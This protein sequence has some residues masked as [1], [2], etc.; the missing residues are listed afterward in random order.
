M[1]AFPEVFTGRFV[2]LEPLALAH[3]PLFLKHYTEEVYRYMSYRPEP[4]LEGM[5][6]HLEALLREAGRVNWLIRL[7]DEAAG[8]ISVIDPT[9]EHG[10]LEIGTLVFR[11]YWGGPANLEAK[12]LLMAYAFET[13]GVER[14]QFKV[15][16]RN[17]RSQKALEK[18]GAVR[19]GVLRRY[20]RVG[21]AWR[22]DVFYS[23]L[24]EEWPAVQERIWARLKS[25]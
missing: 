20:R 6:H 4:S 3:A 24:K 9:P 16:A 2:R 10:R 22:D 18:L 7:G 14:V 12:H 19:E 25:F 11:P 5:E 21:D 15:D 8:R 1:W 17:L 23:V 13:L